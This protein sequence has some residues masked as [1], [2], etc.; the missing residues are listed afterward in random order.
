MLYPT[1]VLLNVG[2]DHRLTRLTHG[3]QIGGFVQ[4]ADDFAYLTAGNVATG[5]PCQ[6]ARPHPVIFKR[7]MVDAS[8]G[9]TLS[10]SVRMR[11]RQ[12]VK[13]ERAVE[14]FGGIAQRFRKCTL[15]AFGFLTRLRS[16]MSRVT[17]RKALRFAIRIMDQGGTDLVGKS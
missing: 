9:T 16:V 3:A 5:V 11:S 6:R 2:E 1:I 8:C 4:Q 13:L 7:M 12:L 15:L 14:H 17:V 10:T